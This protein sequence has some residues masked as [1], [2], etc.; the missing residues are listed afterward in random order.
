MGDIMSKKIIDRT[1]ETRINNFGSQMI[2]IR[3]RMNRDIDVY[4]PEYDYIFKGATYEHFKNGKIKCPY[5]KR[6]YGK[7][8]IGEGKYK[9]SENGKLTKCYHTW[10]EM[11]KRCYDPKLH[12]KCP[13]YKDCEV[14]E[15]FLNFQNFSYWY[16]YSYY[17]IDGERMCLDKDILVKGNK[18]YSPDN[19][20]FVP[21]NINILFVKCNKSR[22]ELPIGVT[23][24]KQTGKFRARCSVYDYDKNKKKIIHLGYYNTPQEA[25]EVYKQFKEQNIKEVA[26]YYKDTIP[27]KLYDAMCKYEVYIND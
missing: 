5:E 24:Y 25:F 27:K 16:E 15:D 11:L 1:G 17:E 21:N 2:I 8:Y 19:C 12:E 26:N 13:T 23:Y 4:F 20:I 9:V 22:G 7:G 14:A 18:I 6:Y 10:H 3:Y